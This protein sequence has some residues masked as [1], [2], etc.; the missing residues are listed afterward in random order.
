MAIIHALIAGSAGTS[1]PPTDLDYPVPGSGDYRSAPTALSGITYSNLGTPYAPGG[2]VS[3]VSNST[4]GLRRSKYDGNFCSGALDTVSSYNLNF[5]AGATFFKAVDDTLISWGSQSDGP[6]PGQSNF[7]IEWLGYLQVPT[8][9]NYN[10]FVESDDTMAV[11]IGSAATGVFNAGN[12][13]VSSSNK[14]LPGQ[15]TS[16]RSANSV[17]LDSTKWYP[18]RIWYSEFTGGCKCQF[19]MQGADGNKYNGD[20]LT[21]AYNSSTGGY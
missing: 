4:P 20:T 15:A 17:T 2:D 14:G 19:Y 6:N 5:F 7:S 9:Q 8:T 3:S 10:I 18:I 11:W 12:C 13:S 21:W 16:T 1:T